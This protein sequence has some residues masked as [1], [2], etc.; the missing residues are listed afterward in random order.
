MSR[1]APPSS[2]LSMERCVPAL[3]GR[4][5]TAIFSRSRSSL[6]DGDNPFVLEQMERCVSPRRPISRDSSGASRRGRLTSTL[7]VCWRMEGGE[8]EHLSRRLHLRALLWP[9][10]HQIFGRLCAPVF[11]IDGVLGSK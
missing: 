11:G 5:P 7:G 3:G 4:G 8:I 10:I 6:T 1:S 2:F 9:H